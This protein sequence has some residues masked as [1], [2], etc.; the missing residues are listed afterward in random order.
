MYKIGG[1]GRI[2]MDPKSGG[3]AGMTND[4][5]VRHWLYSSDVDFQAM[6]TLFR[7]GHYAWTLFIGHTVI[8][9]LLKAHCVMESDSAPPP[10]KLLDLARKANLQPSEEQAG[11]L[12]EI[13]SFEIN[14]QD[15]DEESGFYKQA[16]RRF[17]EGYVNRI[18]E[19]RQWLIKRIKG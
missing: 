3:V 4:E 7:K 18:V 16:N 1:S 8:E 9:K 15:A 19:L 10:L 6:D 14:A 5:L 12:G 2:S 13:S 17:T 11:W